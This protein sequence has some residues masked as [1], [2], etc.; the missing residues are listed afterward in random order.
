MNIPTYDTLILN[1][2]ALIEATKEH[3]LKYSKINLF[4]DNDG[5]GRQAVAYYK[6]IHRNTINQSK[7]IYPNFKDFNE[8]IK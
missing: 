6:T 2:T 7:N 1:S 3:V 5:T 8:F 4:L